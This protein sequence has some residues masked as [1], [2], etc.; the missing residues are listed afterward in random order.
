LAYPDVENIL[1]KIIHESG[2]I[3]TTSDFYI[4]PF[5]LKSTFVIRTSFYAIP[6]PLP[7]LKLPH[8]PASSQSLSYPIP[9]PLPQQG[10]GRKSPS[11]VGEGFREG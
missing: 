9:R 1:V 8:P 4:L 7:K 3:K 5:I 11:L 6:R 2:K 10:K